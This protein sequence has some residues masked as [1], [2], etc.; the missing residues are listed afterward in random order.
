MQ[1]RA[2]LRF[3]LIVCL[4]ALASCNAPPKQDNHLPNVVLIISDDQAWS[5]YSFMA[6]PQIETPRLDQLMSESLTFTR[7]YVSAPLCSPSL[8]TIVSGLYPHQHGITGNDPTFESTQRRYSN[9]WRVERDRVFRPVINR[10]NA[11]PLLTQRLEELNYLS[12]QTGKWWMGS[13]EDG[14]FSHGMTHGDPAQGGR[15]GDEGLIIGREGLQ[16]VYDFIAEAD[17]ADRPFFVWYAPFLPHAPHTPPDSLLDKYLEKAPTPAIARYWAMCEWFDQTC[18]DLLDHLEEKQLSEE[19]LVIYVCDNGWIQEPDKPNRYAARSKRSPY[20]GGIRTP[21]MCKWPGKIVP[22]LD[23]TTLVSSIDI[24]PTVLAAC[25]LPEDKSLPGLNLMD[26]TSLARRTTVFAQAFAHDIQSLAEPTQSLTHRIILS[27]P[28]KLILPDS[29]N[30]PDATVEL[31]DLAKDPTETT[32]LAEE[33][34]EMVKELS[35]QI[36]RWWTPNH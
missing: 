30:L 9:P 32:N 7:G 14:H 13:W 35:G 33:N 20:E 31:F 17:S 25:E 27:Y 22:N 1:K 10:F 36:N 28:W 15:H 5:D 29:T 6:H 11:L 2:I 19:T 18:G 12:L 23:T 8:A 24:V 3:F 26:A 16:P 4:L 34:Q 21:I